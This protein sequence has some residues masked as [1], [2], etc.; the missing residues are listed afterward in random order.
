MK[1]LQDPKTNVILDLDSNQVYLNYDHP[2]LKANHLAQARQLIREWLLKQPYVAAAYTREELIAGGEAR[3]LAQMRLSF[4]PLRSGDVQYC[5][6]PYSMPGATGTTAKPKGTTH[7]SPWHYDTHVPLILL[8]H[9]IVPGKYERRVSPAFLASHASRCSASIRLA[10][11]GR[12][13]GRGPNRPGEEVFDDSL[14]KE[15][16]ERSPAASARAK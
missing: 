14:A 10:L 7:G 9:G 2:N 12:A 1:E 3:L 11:P 4:N 15:P 16:H 5:F 8:G 13:V 6:T